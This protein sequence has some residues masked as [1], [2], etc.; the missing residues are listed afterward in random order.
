MKALFPLCCVIQNPCKVRRS[1]S[2]K[3]LTHHL[4]TANDTAPKMAAKSRATA[5]F[6]ILNSQSSSAVPKASQLTLQGQDPGNAVASHPAPSLLPQ[7]RGVAVDTTGRAVAY[8][9]LSVA[10]GQQ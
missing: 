6:R 7:N 4:A 9:L 5:A 2:A 1:S 10:L 8:V 3:S